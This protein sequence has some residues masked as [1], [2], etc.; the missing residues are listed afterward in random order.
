MSQI[1]VPEEEILR[2]ARSIS[3]QNPQLLHTG[4]ALPEAAGTAR[5]ESPREGHPILMTAVSIAAC[6]AV[7][8]GMTFLIRQLGG[9]MRSADESRSH[10][11]SEIVT[12]TQTGAL[13]TQT[14]EASSAGAADRTGE[15]A[16]TTAPPDQ[17]GTLAAQTDALQTA[18]KNG[19]A[20]SDVHT[21]APKNTGSYTGTAAETTRGAAHTEQTVTAQAEQTAQSAAQT[22]APAYTEA[23]ADPAAER[24]LEAFLAVSDAW[25]TE[26]LAAIG[27]TKNYLTAAV[28]NRRLNAMLASLEP[29]KAVIG[30]DADRFRKAFFDLLTEQLHLTG[31]YDQI[32]PD[33]RGADWLNPNWKASDPFADGALENYGYTL[34]V[35]PFP[36]ESFSEQGKHVFRLG[37][38][39]IALS[40]EEA[41]LR[42]AYVS[43]SADGGP[44]G[45]Y[46]YVEPDPTER[47]CYLQAD[48]ERLHALPV[49]ALGRDISAYA[50]GDV[51]LDGRVD[52][53]DRILL[54]DEHEYYTL[55]KKGH[56]LNDDQLARADFCRPTHVDG[57][58]DPVSVA[59]SEA[60]MA[61]YVYCTYGGDMTSDAFRQL[62]SAGKL[63]W[64]QITPGAE[65]S[66]EPVADGY[67]FGIVTG[68]TESGEPIFRA[69]GRGE[70]VLVDYYSYDVEAE[71][72]NEAYDYFY[73]YPAPV[74]ECRVTDAERGQITAYCLGVTA[75][76][77]AIFRDSSGSLF[78]HDALELF[79][80]EKGTWMVK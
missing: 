8:T 16:Q 69:D 3:A 76:G 55:R 42:A 49:Y 48:A 54:R 66:L 61:Y 36:E 62:W 52:E 34:F 53:T 59:D 28:S 39:Q 67:S 77:F 58:T 2:R 9:S 12:E 47:N 71:F 11:L 73:L 31:I 45:Q 44:M 65:L 78:A 80:Y 24:N 29:Q 37:G 60:V 74:Y 25:C 43:G 18:A 38:G 20:R 56:I 63:R 26:R 51:N 19:T 41:L 4:D 46:V 14:D 75:D 32:N 1:S 6:A 57:G 72:E 17:S 33:Y 21:E 27:R 7:V 50:V 35:L 5:S 79:R 23:A 70:P 10:L 22:D 30:G 13:S 15:A 40:R 64:D 68:R